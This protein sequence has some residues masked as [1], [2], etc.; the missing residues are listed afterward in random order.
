MGSMER[1][2]ESTIRPTAFAWN[3]GAWFGSQGGCSLWMLILG[4][5]LLPKDA[6]AGT[7]CLAGF[8]VVNAWGL[9]LWRARRRVRAY[10]AI[11]AFLLV[12]TVAMIGVVGLV[13]ARGMSEPRE[14]GAFVSTD[15]PWSVLLVCPALLVAFHFRERA[16]LRV[17]PEKRR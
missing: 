16:A 10:A 14:P 5:L 17:P 6:V 7:G 15:L 12:C 13:R 11:Q 3:A 4:L 8:L 9:L 2:G 1:T